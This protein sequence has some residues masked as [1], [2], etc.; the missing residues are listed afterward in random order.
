MNKADRK[1][2]RNQCQFHC[3]SKFHRGILRKHILGH[4]HHRIYS[5]NR[6]APST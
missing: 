2:P 5:G 1:N 6:Y 3:H 4:P